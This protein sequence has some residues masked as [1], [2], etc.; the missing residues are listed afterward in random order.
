MK[1]PTLANK[2][3]Q[4]VCFDLL[5]VM[6]FDVPD[7]R[8]VELAAS[9]QRVGLKTYCYSNM[10]RAQMEALDKQ[11][12]FLHVFAQTFF[13]DDIGPKNEAGYEALAQKTQPMPAAN[14]LVIDDIEHN[15]TAARAAG[16]PTYHFF[17][18]RASSQ[19]L[20][21][22]LIRQGIDL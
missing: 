9:V 17:G 11:H 6:I 8:M 2:S 1:N 21:E 13:A 20:E 15:L 18:N 4:A 16:F 22:F 10:S 5:N 3:I 19:A 7:E 14:C 12:P